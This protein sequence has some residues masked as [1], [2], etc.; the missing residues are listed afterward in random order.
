MIRNDT[1]YMRKKKMC[2]VMIKCS[3]PSG[4]RNGFFLYVSYIIATA[5]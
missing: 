5:I 4:D 3:K 2:Y 1:S